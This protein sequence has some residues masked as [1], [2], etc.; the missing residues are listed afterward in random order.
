M[1]NLENNFSFLYAIVFFVVL[2]FYIQIIVVKVESNCT[3]H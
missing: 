1:G 3:S 2:V